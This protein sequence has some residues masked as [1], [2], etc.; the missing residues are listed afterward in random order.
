MGRAISIRDSSSF[1]ITKLVFA[2]S[3]NRLVQRG[4][5]DLDKPLV[6]HIFPFDDLKDAILLFQSGKTVGKVIIKI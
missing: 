3:M 6:G 5:F 2:Y 4:E 1:L